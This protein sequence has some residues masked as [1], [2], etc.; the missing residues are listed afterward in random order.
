MAALIELLKTTRFSFTAPDSWTQESWEAVS[1]AGYSEVAVL[2]QIY[3]ASLSSGT[4]EVTLQTAL[5]KHDDAFVD[6]VSLTGGTISGTPSLPLKY[7]R[8]L[9]GAG[10]NGGSDNPGFGQYLR[11]KVAATGTGSPAVTATIG[12]KA[13][14]KP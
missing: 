7:Y 10:T 11:V 2:I 6:L 5:E 12:V 14:L 3:E 8:Y 9:A 4:L 13:L 1:L